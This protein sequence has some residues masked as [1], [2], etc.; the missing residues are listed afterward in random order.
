MIIPQFCNQEFSR[1]TLDNHERNECEDRPT[2]CKYS[3]IGCQW[4]GPLHESK[5]HEAQCAHPKSKKLI[6]CSIQDDDDDL[7]L[8]FF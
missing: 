6:F 7:T 1:S 5:E 3:I 8:C 4:C 2:E